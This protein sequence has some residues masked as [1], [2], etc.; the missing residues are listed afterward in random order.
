MRTAT[1]TATPTTQAPG[2]VVKSTGS[3]NLPPQTADSAS[4]ACAKVLNLLDPMRRV[5]VERRAEDAPQTCRLGYLRA[6]AGLAS[7][8]GAIK[9]FCL[10]CVGWDRVAVA[11]CSAFACPLWAYRPFGAGGDERR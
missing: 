6:A 3:I 10:E 5:Q 4:H 11:K 8:R 7:P 2:P 9:A 1:S